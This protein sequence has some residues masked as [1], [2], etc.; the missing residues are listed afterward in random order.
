MYYLS[1]EPC[2]GGFYVCVFKRSWIKKKVIEEIFSIIIIVILI[3]LMIFKKISKFHLIHIIVTFILFYKYN[4]GYD[5][6]NHGLYNFLSFIAVL[7]II[8]LFLFPLNC[9]IY[10]YRKKNKKYLIIYL[11]SLFSFIIFC[12]IIS[13][14][15]MN[16]EDWPKGLNNTLIDN[17]INKYGCRIKIPNY[18]PYHLGPY[19]FDITKWQRVK[20]KKRNGNEKKKLLEYSKSSYINNDTKRI[21]FPITNKNSIYFQAFGFEENVQKNLVDMDNEKL[22]KKIFGD[23]IPEVEVDFSKNKDGEMI[24]HLNYNR[25][26]S[27]IKKKLEKKTTPYANNILLLYID[28]LSRGNSLRKLKKTTKFFE[29]FMPYKGEH[30]PKYLKENY[31]SFQFLKYHSFEGCTVGNY[32][33]IFYGKKKEEA[34]K[35]RI[36]KYLN[37]NGYVTGYANDYCYYDNTPSYHEIS[38]IEAYDHQM[39]LCDPNCGHYCSMTIRCLYGKAN[40]EHLYNYGNQFWREYKNNRKYLQIVSNDAHENTLEPVKYMD[41]TIFNFLKDLYKDNLLKD[42]TILLISDHGAALP[43]FYHLSDFYS[44]E[45]SLPM[46]FI[47]INDRNHKTYE[48]QYKYIYQNQQTFITG[49]DIYDTILHLIYGD[50][51][52]SIKNNSEDKFSPKSNLGKSLFTKIDQKSRSPKIYEEMD[53]KVCV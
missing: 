46:F 22:I 29:N 30:N 17:D 28:S 6:D 44:L 16:C 48:E 49:Y 9:L 35:I 50:Y 5:F 25:T 38:Q 31:H 51:Y 42:T 2:Y 24:I 21:G 33:R 7:F 13:N 1:L 32:P 52:Y 27:K 20:C 26:L 10:L 43:S 34:N 36:T 4:H 11:I 18:C 15:C 39:T 3:E 8:F 53:K 14:K 23:N 12:I 19:L 45:F 37:E 40:Y 41:D 47:I